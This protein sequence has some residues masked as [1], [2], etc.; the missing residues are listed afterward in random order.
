M[1]DNDAAAAAA[2]AAAPTSVPPVVPPLHRR[3]KAQGRVD[4]PEQ[5]IKKAVEYHHRS[6]NTSADE[7]DVGKVQGRAA[8]SAPPSPRV[9]FCYTPPIAAR[10][11]WFATVRALTTFVTVSAL[12]ALVVYW[13]A[14][15]HLVHSFPP[16]GR[17]TETSPSEKT[18]FGHNVTRG[19]LNMATI[20]QRIVI[21]SA[22]TLTILIAP[23]HPKVGLAFGA[24][25]ASLAW[26]VRHA[27]VL[28]TVGICVV[29]E[30]GLCD[31]IR[32]A[33]AP[34]VCTQLVDVEACPNTLLQLTM[35]WGDWFSGIAVR[36]S[37]T[38]AILIMLCLLAMG[39]LSVM[40]T[41]LC[42]VAV[43]GPPPRPPIPPIPQPRMPTNPTDAAVPDEQAAVPP[44][45]LV[46]SEDGDGDD[47]DDDDD[48][49]T[50]T[51][52]EQENPSESKKGQ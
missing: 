34:N 21:G 33:V 45:N 30:L 38:S 16:F 4:I 50:H 41:I 20:C 11:R 15:T 35:W 29:E 8:A 39:S 47:D 43:Y 36:Q 1:T 2:A 31:Y 18:D 12:I 48:D 9:E 46:S 23:Q 37:S 42:A 24:L 10:R 52:Q 22:A 26:E 17:V 19:F 51:Q 25:L 5:C 44:K 14:N 6:N 32:A 7:E 40:V 27:V 13:A 28:Y 49:D 3:K